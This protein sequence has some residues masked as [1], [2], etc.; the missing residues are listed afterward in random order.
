MRPMENLHPPKP[1]SFDGVPHAMRQRGVPPHRVAVFCGS[2]PDASA[3]HLEAAHELG[4][5][6]GEAGH[7]VI[8]G[9]GPIGLMGAVATGVAS[10]GADLIGIIPTFLLE[11]ESA[12]SCPPRQTIVTADLLERKKIMM[13][14]SDAYIVLPGGYGTLDELTEVL[15]AAA[16]GV[17]RKPIVLLN[18][19]NSFSGLVTLLDR[20]QLDGYFGVEHR[21]LMEVVNNTESVVRCIA[22]QLEG[23]ER[24]SA[25]D[26]DKE[27]KV[28]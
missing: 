19:D 15:A 5:L 8:Y 7:V 9:A 6:L 1:T 12:Y 10:T 20:L 27:K 14:I 16:L 21:G 2:S 28:A 23:A 25:A 17:E 13:S 11:R 26:D 3:T 24:C 22:Q 4:R 18:L